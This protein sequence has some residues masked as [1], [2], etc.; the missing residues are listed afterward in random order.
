MIIYAYFWLIY[1]RPTEGGVL[2]LPLSQ[3]E[4][5]WCLNGVISI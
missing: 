3:H 4:Q 1:G 2:D 5:I